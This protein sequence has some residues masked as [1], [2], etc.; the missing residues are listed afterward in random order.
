MQQ[1]VFNGRAAYLLDDEP[2]WQ[3]MELVAE[4][5]M[6]LEQG[7]SGLED[8][9][10]RGDSLRLSLTFTA[11]L[12]GAAIAAFRNGLQG[13]N[14]QL[15]LCPLWPA[16]FWPEDPPLISAPWYVEIGDGAAPSIQPAS[17][18]PLGRPACPLMVG[19]L[20]KVP[21]PEMFGE[22]TQLLEIEFTENDSSILTP[23]AFNPPNTLAAANGVRPLFPFDADWGTGPKTGAAEVDLERRQIGEVRVTQDAYYT[24]L[25]R[26]T[27]KQTLTLQ[28]SDPWNLLSFF[29][30]QGAMRGNFWLPVAIGEA[31]LTADVLAVDAA[32]QVDNPGALGTNVFVCLNDLVNRVPLQ[33]TGVAG[34]QWN[35][36]GAVGTAFKGANTRVESLML[37]RFD[38]TKVTIKWQDQLLAEAEVP[39]KEVP[40]ETAGTSL[41]TIGLTMGPLPTNA[42]LYVFTINYPGAPQTWRFTGFERNLT[43]GDDNVYVSIGIENDD[44]TET[45]TMERQSVTIKCRNFAGNPLALMVPF[46]LEWPLTV[47]IFEAD[48]TVDAAGNLRCLFVGEVTQAT[49]DGPFIDATAASLSSLFDR[50]IPRRLYQPG[51]NWVLFEPKCGMVR[52]GWQW[53]GTVAGFNP[54]T[55]ELSL[56]G[57]AST[58]IPVNGA[59][60]A[61]HFFAGGYLYAGAG[62]AVQY[63]MI[64]DSTAVA[65]G[66]LSLV[67]A[68]PFTSVPANGTLVYF[69]PGCDGAST[70]CAGRFNNYA[71][72]GGT[73]FIPA[74]NPT[75][76]QTMPVTGTKK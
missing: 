13:L 35:L 60:L 42:Y 16:W 76:A 52:A 23:A 54:A 17:A 28:D 70:T 25:S 75:M 19:R 24:Q 29:Q 58:A 6:A 51:C 7:L 48:V 12:E 37:A 65:A 20:L 67:L 11:L 39:F 47:E 49:P 66:A 53:V 69:Y 30:S 40:W 1:V 45:A 32:L 36:A 4:V 74:A 9:R 27:V 33:V 73:P 8:R 3:K 50:Q 38:D 61:A 68:T 71:N 63:R 22:D 34:S 14:T 18:L 26:R 56:T 44:I 46:A 31:N 72:F 21:E 2:D 5:P 55:M 43:D 64:S 57:V 41:E 62:N 15:V 59:V 10:Q